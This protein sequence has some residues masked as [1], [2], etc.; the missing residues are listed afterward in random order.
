MRDKSFSI[1]LLDSYGVFVFNT[2]GYLQAKNW[3]WLGAPLFEMLFVILPT[4]CDC[5]AN[6]GS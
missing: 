4:S 6:P 2:N 5:S 3:A 1:E